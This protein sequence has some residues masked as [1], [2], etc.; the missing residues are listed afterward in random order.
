METKRDKDGAYMSSIFINDPYRSDCFAW[1]WV[2]ISC[3]V[4]A[5]S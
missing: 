2:L 4:S 1:V 3:L 5:R